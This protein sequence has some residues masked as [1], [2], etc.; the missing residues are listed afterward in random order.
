MTGQRRAGR[1]A[2]LTRWILAAL[3]V[4]AL[5]A[6]AE[7]TRFEHQ[8]EARLEPTRIEVRRLPVTIAG[9]ESAPLAKLARNE[10]SR[11]DAHRRAILGVT[12][13]SFRVSSEAALTSL[14]DRRSARVC[15]RPARVEVTVGYDPLKIVIASELPE[16]GCPYQAVLEHERGH[17]RLYGEF[18]AIVE[19]A[20]RAELER[21]FDGFLGFAESLDA[22][23][24]A[25]ER[26][27]L[28]SVR[29]AL[30]ARMQAGR[31]LHERH[32]TDE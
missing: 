10:A 6:H 17:A 13:A 11:N 30:D 23:Q 18:L 1:P 20:V 26:L 24:A 16:G 4:V 31:A 9:I 19:E 25:L 27:L 2:R 29:R 14:E 22:A 21:E 15:Y 7:G 12:H 5:D 3:S 28:T 8:C 32:D